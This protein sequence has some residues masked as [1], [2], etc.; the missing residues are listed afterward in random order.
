MAK[1]N[2]LLG[3]GA[4]LVACIATGALGNGYS[5]NL[6][7]WC[8]IAA[9]TAASLRFVLLIGE[10]NFATA[11]FFGIG[12]YTAG[13]ATTLLSW[14]FVIAVLASGVLACVVGAVFG[15]ITL[16]A[17]GP[18]FLLIGFAFTEVMRIVYTRS[19]TLGGNSGMIGIFP[20]T[21]F[22][23]AFPGFVVLCA[24]GLML[25]LYVIEQSQFG[26]L[27]NAIRDNENVARSVGMRVHL[28]K[29]VCFCLSCFVT[30]V[31]GSLHAFVNNVI[32]PPDFGFLLSTF[33]LAY[34]KVG[35]EDHP[36]GPVAG[37]VVLVLLSSA[38]LSFG[39]SEH[40]FYGAAIVLAMLLLPNGIVGTVHGRVRL[41][42]RRRAALSR[43]RE[44]V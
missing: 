25:A 3:I 29:V 44:G 21:G 35:G 2:L 14:P 36:L 9:L 4:T 41:K 16:R 1:R 43:S 33:A 13:V 8:A 18:Y 6:I 5:G 40:V 31:A 20:P 23:H 12:A 17:K 26:R 7:A 32:S 15:F 11:A 27:L 42:R 34:L 22:G 10:L 39:A 30:G 19:D 38:T 37:A 24:G 28:V